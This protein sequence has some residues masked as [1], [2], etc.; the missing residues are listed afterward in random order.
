MLTWHHP[1]W[2]LT[3]TA[4]VILFAIGLAAAAPRNWSSTLRLSLALTY[5]AVCSLL[6]ECYSLGTQNSPWLTI[7]LSTL[8]GPLIILLL[9]LTFG[10]CLLDKLLAFIKQRLNMVQLMVFRQ[11]YQG[12]PT[13]TL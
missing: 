6:L 13:N 11:E 10:P 3:I 4:L 2:L 12:L 7:L 1:L 8:M 5:L 9:L